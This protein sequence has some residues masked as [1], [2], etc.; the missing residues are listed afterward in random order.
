M[1]ELI[2]DILQILNT[3]V[4]MCFLSAGVSRVSQKKMF[5]YILKIKNKNSVP[6]LSLETFIL[7]FIL[8]RWQPCLQRKQRDVL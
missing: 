1:Y 7:L 6:A 2:L 4:K 8:E 3:I 5:S